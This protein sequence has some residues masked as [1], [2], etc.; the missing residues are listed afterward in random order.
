MCKSARRWWLQGWS[1]QATVKKGF[2][3]LLFVRIPSRNTLF[4][5]QETTSE[6]SRWDAENVAAPGLGPTHIDMEM[7]IRGTVEHGKRRDERDIESTS[8]GWD[9]AAAQSVAMST[10]PCIRGS[11]SRA[12][13]FI[14][15]FL[16][17]RHSTF[18]SLV[19]EVDSLSQRHFGLY[20][21]VGQI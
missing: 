15:P 8:V 6:P 20:L 11:P 19:K 9:V 14:L 16:V 10:K 12:K 17:C 21:R 4:H 13:R 18:L 7:R 1:S 2:Y 5:Q 3:C